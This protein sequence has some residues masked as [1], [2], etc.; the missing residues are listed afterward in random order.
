M[1]NRSLKTAKNKQQYVIALS[2]VIIVAVAFYFLSPFVGY[3]V[4][5]F[6]LLVTVSLLAMFLDIAPVLLAAI[7]SALIWDFFFIPP[8]YT[9]SVGDT[10]D[11]LTLLM[12]LLIALVNT[13][14]THKIRKAENRAKEK[15]ER[16]HT[17]ILYNT[18]LNSLSHE[19][20]TP[21]AAI[22]G[23]TDNL[24]SDNTRLTPQNRHELIAEIS[25]ASFRLNQQVD[26]LLNM[27][28]LESGFIQPKNDWCDINELVYEVVKR[29]EE[30]K[31]KQSIHIN[32]SPDL[33][34]FKTDA[35]MLEQVLY[36]LLN[37]AAQYSP[38]ETVIDISAACHLDVL[39]LIVEDNGH[40]FPP[41]EIKYVFDKFYRLK[42]SQTGGTGL[43]LSI[44]KGFT[45]AMK[46]SV[47]L[48]NRT[49]GGARFI[50]QIPAET[51]YLKNLKNE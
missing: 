42:S 43:G 45:E 38:A 12:Y 3:R 19:L 36:N 4:T 5:A 27:S 46:G 9:F 31:I 22:I 40:G 6:S 24:L 18:L 39:E 44:V 21:I 16:E 48:E 29:I 17:V 35:G 50:V 41:E 34:L 32:I 37:N 26:N 25:K 13:V 28:R 15:E 11:R 49:T 51:N 7:L 10:E 2:M 14:L 47:R 8:R 33:P 23:A 1:A 30:N 20:R